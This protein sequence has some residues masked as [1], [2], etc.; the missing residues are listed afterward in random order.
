MNRL[1]NQRI[2]GLL[3]ICIGVL[4]IAVIP[5]QKMDDNKLFFL[6]GMGATLSQTPGEREIMAYWITLENNRSNKTYK[7]QSFEPIIPDHIQSLIVSDD[8]K[9]TVGKKLK[10]N[11]QIEIKGEII[12]NTSQLNEIEIGNIFSML[13]SYKVIY[14]DDKE[15]ILNR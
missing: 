5:I 14:D 12:I 15:V 8:V 13:K 6:S 11:K 2:L 3:M 1:Y 10:K 7:I 9:I 4:I